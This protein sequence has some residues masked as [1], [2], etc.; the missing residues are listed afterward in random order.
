[1]SAVQPPHSARFVLWLGKEASFDPFTVGGKTA[2]LSRLAARY[3]VPPGFALTTTAFRNEAHTDSRET[4]ITTRVLSDRLY[5]EVEEAYELLGKLCGTDSPAVAVRSSAVDEDGGDASFAGQHET[6][7]NI[8][9]ARA[10]MEAIERCWESF[11]A[12]HALEYRRKQGLPIEGVTAAVLVQQLVVADV[13]AVMFTAD[14]VSGNQNEMIINASW[15]L[16]ESIVG[17]T[18]TPDVYRVRKDGLRITQQQISKKRHMTV[19]MPNGTRE[20]RIPAFLHMQPTLTNEQAI[21]IARMG[22]A[23]EREMDRPVDVECELSH[24][25]L[26][27]LQCRPI[28]TL[29]STRCGSVQSS[30]PAPAVITRNINPA[31]PVQIETPPYFPVRWEQHDD[32]LLLWTID[33]VHWPEPIPPL[34]YSIAGDTMAHGLM[35]AAATYDLPIAE[36]RTR[37]INT[38]RY[39]AN[40]PIPSTAEEETDRAERS[41]AKLRAAMAQLHNSWITDWLPEVNRHIQYWED[42]DLENASMSA[43]L[44]HLDETMVRANHLWCIHFVLSS[45]MHGAISQFGKLHRDLFG[46]STLDAYRL[47]RGFDNKILQASREL[48]QL[49]RLALTLPQVH[50]ALIGDADDL[51]AQLGRSNEGRTFLAK[52]RSFL[53]EYGQRGEGLNLARP[54]WIENLAPVIESLRSMMAQPDRDLSA[55]M[56]GWT[57][58]RERLVKEALQTLC[59]YPQPVQD[60]FAFLLAAAQD[61]TVLKEDHNFWIDARG[62]HQVRRVFLEFGR[63]FAASGIIDEPEDVFYLM[64]DEVREI[65]SAP[66]ASGRRA[67]ITDRRLEMERFRSIT[68]PPELGKRPPESCLSDAKHKVGPKGEFATTCTLHGSAGSAGVARGV[69]KVVLSL[70]QAAK[71]RKGDV[72]VAETLSSSWTPLFATASAVVTNTGGILSHAA[73]VA[74][75]Y[76]IPAVL[77]TDEATW[78]LR[79][80]DLLEV[81]GNRGTVRVVAS[82]P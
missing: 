45:P 80:G 36:V 23:L 26:Y 44:A 54:S 35:A 68:P 13:S 20:V 4:G 29:G 59:G 43:L 25:T 48:W 37:R 46:G 78:Q 32:E 77:G 49:S 42:F 41:R 61:A 24:G 58:E 66:S 7:L 3:P 28:T 2:S 16:G 51:I 50:A 33:R 71:L 40:V 53:N 39:Q 60:E 30:S 70:N 55:E 21:S 47:L 1:M 38:Y 15:G 12:P 82:E 8:S 65:A 74:R 31:S 18:V 69:A 19:A 62:M 75:E 9:G 22:I 10:V 73:V 79:D 81:D 11:H 6:F 64:L 52:L 57:M 34:I 5:A 72:L 14:P 76:G 63:R 67:L 27:L 17:G 56:L